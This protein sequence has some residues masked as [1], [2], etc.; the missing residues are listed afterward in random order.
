MRFELEHTTHRCHA[1]AI[2]RS[3]PIF[4]RDSARCCPAYC[5]AFCFWKKNSHLPYCGFCAT[6]GWVGAPYVFFQ[7]S[8]VPMDAAFV[9]PEVLKPLHR[10][11]MVGGARCRGGRFL[12][13]L[14][15]AQR[16]RPIVNVRGSMLML[17][18]GLAC[19]SLAMPLPWGSML[20]L[21]KGHVPVTP[22]D[23]V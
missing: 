3:S 8:A 4:L 7:T 5:L 1:S 20:L 13:R 12:S 16:R 18:R 2:R 10:N 22:R 17:C 21:V 23:E 6:V 19:R 11:F 15:K 9:Q 14:P